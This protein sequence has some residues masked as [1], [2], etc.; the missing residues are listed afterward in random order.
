MANGQ[1]SGSDGELRRRN[2]PRRGGGK[3]KWAMQPHHSIQL[4]KDWLNLATKLFN[5]DE[6]DILLTC[7]EKNE[8]LGLLAKRLSDAYITSPGRAVGRMVDTVRKMIA[9]KRSLSEVDIHTALLRY[10]LQPPANW[11][12]VEIIEQRLDALRYLERCADGV[13][14]YNMQVMKAMP[15]TTVVTAKTQ[16][17]NDD[18][19]STMLSTTFTSD[20]GTTSNNLDN[21]TALPWTQAKLSLV[22]LTPPSKKRKAASELPPEKKA[23]LHKKFPSPKK[24]ATPRKKTRQPAVVDISTKRRSATLAQDQTESPT[25]SLRRARQNPGTAAECLTGGVDS[26]LLANIFK[27]TEVLDQVAHYEDACVRRI[28]LSTF[29]AD[30]QKAGWKDLE[31]SAAQLIEDENCASREFLARMIVSGSYQLINEAL[32]QEVKPV[33]TDCGGGPSPGRRGPWILFRSG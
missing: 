29:V 33:K 8:V 26:A 6:G 7:T 24:R 22:S 18:P 16:S 21:P 12:G 25:T 9:G 11:S 20:T 1:S 19:G 30:L 31:K 13:E 4:Q 17:R 27:A 5:A 23:T 32:E 10:S 28:A 3:Y 15:K 14:E 2:Q